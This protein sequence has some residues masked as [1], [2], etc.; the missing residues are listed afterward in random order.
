MLELAE[1]SVRA[2]LA[3]AG[4]SLLLEARARQSSVSA[5]LGG[6]ALTVP[7]FAVPSPPQTVGSDEW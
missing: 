2:R 7:A 5:W 3:S 6:R 4:S 1:L